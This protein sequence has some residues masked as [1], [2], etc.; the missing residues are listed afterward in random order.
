[1]KISFV[2]P[3]YNAQLHLKNCVRSIMRQSYK[4]I[5]II[6]VNDGSTD[7][8]L[9]IC[10]E[11]KD[12][13]ERITVICQKNSGVS[14]ARN[15]GMMHATGEW[16][17][18]VDSDD[19]ISKDYVETFE[20]YLNE[21]FDFF[22]GD[23]VGHRGQKEINIELIE[24]KQFA[25]YE[26]GLLNKYAIVGGP[27]LTS[28]CGKL[29]RA[30]FLKENGVLFPVCLKK[31][32]DALFN[33]YVFHY[34]RKGVYINKP[35]YYYRRCE[36][37]ASNKYDASSLDNYKK[38]LE[39]LEQFLKHER[40]FAEMNADYQI[41]IIFHFFYCVATDFCH[42]DN[43]YNYKKRKERFKQGRKTAPFAS[44]FENAEKVKLPLKER[45]LFYCIKYKCF[46]MV[47]VMFK[48]KRLIGV[49]R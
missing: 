26:K 29:Y 31:S 2:V 4:D 20:K 49:G 5:Q 1:M 11:L 10:Y 25:L 23:E 8:S 38:H 39:L 14:A 3:I 36:K 24:R 42:R 47:D 43:P 9:K 7:E 32:E 13:D 33:Q 15:N 18:F 34:A 30:S 45:V 40:I 6:L 17:A 41:R 48:I 37:S 46:L 22:C 44:G 21:D 27:H 35:I 28:A 19:C 12:E 16:I